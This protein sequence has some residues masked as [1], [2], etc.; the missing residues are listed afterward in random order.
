MF[1]IQDVSPYVSA[2]ATV[3]STIVDSKPLVP[4]AQLNSF[5]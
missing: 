2:P 1:A 3:C 5:F 4:Q